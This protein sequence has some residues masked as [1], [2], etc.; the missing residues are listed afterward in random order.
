[1]PEFKGSFADSKFHIELVL[2]EDERNRKRDFV[3]D[4][5]AATEADSNIRHLG[6]QTR[7]VL[8]DPKGSAIDALCKVIPR[9]EAES[10]IQKLIDEH[11][12][13]YSY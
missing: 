6:E 3:S 4:I 9:Q 12:S 7:R 1:M 8:S 10:F 11:A 2:S 13:S 5:R